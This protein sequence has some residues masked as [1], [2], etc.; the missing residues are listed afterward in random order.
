[1]LD[2]C[3]N[4]GLDNDVLFNTLKSV[5]MLFKPRGYKLYRSNIMIGQ[6]LKYIDNTKYLGILHFVKH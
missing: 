2:I 6:V 5:C 4:Y 1:M 3:Y